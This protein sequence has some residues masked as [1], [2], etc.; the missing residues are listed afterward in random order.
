MGMG[1]KSLKWEGIGTKNLFPH[2]SKLQ[3]VTEPDVPGYQKRDPNAG[4]SRVAVLSTEVSG[5]QWR[6]LGT[7]GHRSRTLMVAFDWQGMTSC[8]CSIAALGLGG[9]DV[10]ELLIDSQPN[11]RPV[12]QQGQERCGVFMEP[13]LQC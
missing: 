2:T 12:S 8:L 7:S 9:N 13:L 1:M 3:L 5:C 10:D 6:F 11:R 4:N